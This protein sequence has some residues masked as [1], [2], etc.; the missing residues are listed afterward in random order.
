MTRRTPSLRIVAITCGAVVA[1]G[2]AAVVGI[3][4]WANGTTPATAG[5]PAGTTSGAAT[6]GL[7]SV[8]RGAAGGA[9]TGS[10]GSGSTP[11]PGAVSAPGAAATSAPTKASELSPGTPQTLATQPP[12]SPRPTTP[13]LTGP[14]P[15]TASAQG[16]RLVAGFPSQVIPVLAGIQVV[17]SSVSGQGDRLQVGLE[18]SSTADPATVTSRYVQSFRDAGFAVAPSP[19]ISG[20]T[21]TQ[22]VRGVDGAVLTVTGRVGGG[23][24][25]T[26]AAT[27]TTTG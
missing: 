27:L 21:A 17:A 6:S 20:S 19:A 26:I 23:T 24:E 22:F 18:A 2:V 7:P 14:L 9:S 15:A 5:H 1:L 12:P 3:T 11:S 10:A 13:S 25:L 8:T 4:A 16:E